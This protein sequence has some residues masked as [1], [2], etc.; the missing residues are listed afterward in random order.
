MNFGLDDN[1]YDVG[2]HSL[3][4]I[5]V[6][7]LINQKLNINISVLDLFQNPSISSLANH[8]LNEFKDNEISDIAKRAARQR[9]SIGNNIKK[10]IEKHK[11][12]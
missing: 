6:K 1:F 10:I 5:K 9:K 11:N 8:F 7:N 4:M 3:L 12:G 2:G